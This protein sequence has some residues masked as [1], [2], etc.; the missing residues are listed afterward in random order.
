MGIDARLIAERCEAGANLQA[1][2]FRVALLQYLFHAGLLDEWR[3]GA[4]LSDSV[5]HL[6]ATFPIE[7]GVQGFDSAAFMSR[8]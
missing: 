7:L 6:S 4:R 1:V 2:F 5:F 3:E 8:L